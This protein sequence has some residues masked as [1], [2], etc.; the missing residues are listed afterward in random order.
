M[1]LNGKQKLEIALS[2]Y[3]RQLLFDIRIR[4]LHEGM[5]SS[6]QNIIALNLLSFIQEILEKKTRYHV[7]HA[8]MII[9]P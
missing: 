5:I 6:V 9:L 2:I 4:M 7:F 3:S 8:V 1:P